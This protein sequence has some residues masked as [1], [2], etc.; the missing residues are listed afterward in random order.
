MCVAVWAFYNCI[1]HKDE[2]NTLLRV[3]QIQYT[4]NLGTADINFTIYEKS[5]KLYVIGA[6][7]YGCASGRL[8]PPLLRISP[9]L[10]QC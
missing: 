8:A 10:S 9:P 6:H 1:T 7:T 2:Q 4:L 5:I 3:F